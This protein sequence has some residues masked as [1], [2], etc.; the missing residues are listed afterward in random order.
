M[1]AV[2]MTLEKRGEGIAIARDRGGDET[3]IWIATDLCHPLLPT[4]LTELGSGLWTKA[5]CRASGLIG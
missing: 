3:G 5:A 2:V 4:T 1:D